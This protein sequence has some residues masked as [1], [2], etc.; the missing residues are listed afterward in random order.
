MNKMRCRKKIGEMLVDA[1]Y[2]AQNNLEYLLE[3]QYSSQMKLGEFLICRNVIREDEFVELLSRQLHINRYSVERYPVTSQLAELLDINLVNRHETIPIERQEREI[4]VAMK[5]PLNFSAI[6]TVE[7][8]LD[9][10]VTIVICTSTEYEELLREIYGLS[11][12]MEKIVNESCDDEITILAE[13]SNVDEV[14]VSSL[15]NMAEGAPAV[16]MVNWMI[17][18]AVRDGASDIHISPEKTSIQLRF[19]VDGQLREMSSP[20]RP[21]MLPITSRVKIL[22]NMDLAQ[23]RVPQ[24]GRFSAKI[25]GRDINIRASTVPTTEGE[26]IVLRLLDMS[27]RNYTLNDLGMREDERKVIDGVI[28]KPHGLVLSTGPTGSGK[29]TSL[30]AILQELNKP[31]VNIITVEDPVEYRVKGIRQLQ[32]NTRA[33]MSFASGLRSILRQ[34]PDIIM[35]GEIRDAETAQIAAQAS[36]TGHKVFST[37][38][39]NSA[40]GAIV[41]LQD[42]GL[43]PFII[44]SIL[45]T[46]FAQRLVRTVCPKCAEPYTPQDHILNEWG[47]ETLDGTSFLRG[48]GC[49]H[50]MHTGYKG[51][52]GI[53]EILPINSII[54]EMIVKRR[55]SDE[56]TQMACE[57]GLLRTLKQ[58]ALD[59]VINGI[60]TFEEAARA[61][62]T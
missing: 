36:L 62:M 22:A 41:R 17:S 24:D 47:V 8:I 31:N 15:I 45:L 21:M 54:Q 11:T 59:K 46:S 10:R 32:L 12:G 5:D 3:E 61:V 48:A 39:T 13:E 4:T 38:H 50:C 18:Q 57:A 33:G 43:E 2:I 44:A 51:R 23:S 34:D 28:V 1:G 26:N 53:Y 52:H 40:A 14:Q 29:S 55:S 37:I 60:T 9:C 20:P 25:D 7:E 16:K 19:R 58:D 42:M 6:D 56:I 35:I 30:Y 49:S 27:G